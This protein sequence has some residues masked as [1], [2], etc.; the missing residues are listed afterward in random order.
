[1]HCNS[2]SS[3]SLSSSFHSFS[4]AS[5]LHPNMIPSI[6]P[7][8]TTT[9]HYFILGARPRSLQ[10][11]TSTIPHSFRLTL[12]FNLLLTPTLQSP[13]SILL[14]LHVT[15]KSLSTPSVSTPTLRLSSPLH[16]HFYPCFIIGTTILFSVS[17][18]Q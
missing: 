3:Y 17:I 7:S 8:A 12:T 1:M 10:P 11:H 13:P 16:F 5:T 18:F 4:L 2:T 9:K 14:P 6:A 15:H